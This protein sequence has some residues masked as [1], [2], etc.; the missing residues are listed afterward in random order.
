MYESLLRLTALPADTL[1]YCGHDYT[2]ENYQFAL[3]IEPGNE[4]ILKRLNEV[5]KALKECKQTVPSTIRIE[6]ETNIFLSSDAPEVKKALGM[7]KAD[8]VQVFTKLRCR[9]DV[10]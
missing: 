6:K 10:F 1:V 5:K 7:E 2:V 4:A 3:T 9:K 8:A